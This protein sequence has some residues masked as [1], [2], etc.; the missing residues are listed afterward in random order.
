MGDFVRLAPPK[1]LD[2]SSSD[3]IEDFFVPLLAHATR[4]D[5]GVGFFSSGWLRLT[6]TGMVKF[7]A[8]GGR[9]RL[10]ARFGL[11]ETRV[12][13]ISPVVPRV[14][15]QI[16]RRRYGGRHAETAKIHQAPVLFQSITREDAGLA[17]RFAF[18]GAV[19]DAIPGRSVDSHQLSLQ[20]VEKCALL[21]RKN[22]GGLMRLSQHK[23][24]DLQGVGGQ[25]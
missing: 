4:Y 2:T 21:R 6:A 15:G 25:R 5:R 16:E 1:T 20:S 13:S 22:R 24:P 23:D 18:V 9:A 8:N 7:A 11:S 10:E 19:G 17:D 3:L 12:T 14:P